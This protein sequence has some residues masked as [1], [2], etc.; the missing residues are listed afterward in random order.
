MGEI[1]QAINYASNA[2][3]AWALLT[4]GRQWD[5]YSTFTPKPAKERLSFSVSID[6]D[7]FVDRMQL[8]TFK[9]IE[10]LNDHLKTQQNRA[11][12]KTAVVQ[13]FETQDKGFLHLLKSKTA[14]VTGDICVVLGDLQVRFG[15][16][17]S[18]LQWT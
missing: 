1:T 13:L 18:V 3:V 6:D 14:L 11:T 8:L 5:S 17:G 16:G 10:H 2:G 15:G 4:N 9:A 12:V 7:D